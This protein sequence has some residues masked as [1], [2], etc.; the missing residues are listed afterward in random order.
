MSR[1]NERKRFYHEPSTHEIFQCLSIMP[2][3]SK[4]LLEQ[5]SDKPYSDFLSWLIDKNFYKGQNEKITIKRIS[6][7]FRTETVKITKWI[8]EIYEQIFDL[9]YDKPELFQSNGV[10]VCLYL[11][12]F[13]SSCYFYTSFP[14]L[15]REFETIRYPFTKAKVGTNLFWVKRVEH[16]FEEGT[17][18]ITLSLEAGY[19][20][21]YREFALDKALFQGRIHYTDVFELQSYELDDKIKKIYS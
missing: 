20:N 18:K 13:D 7:D 14:V 1:T 12:Y 5:N 17:A 15:P 21:K 4:I 9:N 6:A 11:K 16:E 2:M 10:P 3:Y 8:K 19:I